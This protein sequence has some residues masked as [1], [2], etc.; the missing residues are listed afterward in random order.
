L[1]RTKKKDYENYIINAVWNRVTQRIKNDSVL[2]DLQYDLKPV[3]QQFIRKS[4]NERYFI[5]LYFPQLN[6]GIECNEHHH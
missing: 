4:D 3:S 1:S 2:K 5:D 6:I